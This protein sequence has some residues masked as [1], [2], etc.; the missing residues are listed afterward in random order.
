MRDLR[1]DIAGLWHLANGLPV[2][3]GG[4]VILFI[5]A[6]PGEGVSSV[7]VSFAQLA[8]SHAPRMTWLIDLNI[9]RNPLCTAFSKGIVKDAGRPMH[10][11]DASLGA[12]QIYAVPGHETERAF[13][14]LLNAHQIEGQRLLVTRFRSDRLGP[15]QKVQLRTAPG[16][17]AA[18]RKA[19]DWVVVDAPPV[20]QSR[21]GL[22]FVSQADG[23][24]LVVKADG[25]PAA[26]VAALRRDVELHGGKVL[27]VVLNQVGDDA[28]V[29][30]RLAGID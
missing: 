22:A 29:V 12:E 15:G 24:V 4:R 11:L 13:G 10:A 8:A 6:H 9:R 28:R 5:G 1:Q 19:A 27:G 20:D 23:V 18:L 21:A 2:D 26:D 16:W 17:W 3:R 14:R 25:A 7:A 30:G